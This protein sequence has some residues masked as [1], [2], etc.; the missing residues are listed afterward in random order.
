MGI[1]WLKKLKQINIIGIDLVIENKA[2][3]RFRC[4][5]LYS[6][7]S[8]MRMAH[9]FDETMIETCI[10]DSNGSNLAIAFGFR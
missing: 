8:R 5:I 10:S 9:M 6:E 1:F 2:G 3:Q 4:A 7:V